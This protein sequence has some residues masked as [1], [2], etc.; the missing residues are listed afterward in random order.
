VP[1]GYEVERTGLD[2]DGTAY[3]VMLGGDAPGCSCPGH[4]RWGHCKHFEELSKMVADGRLPA[5]GAA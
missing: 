1:G 4:T 5:G 2:A 3:H